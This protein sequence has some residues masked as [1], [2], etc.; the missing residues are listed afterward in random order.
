MKRIS[1]AFLVAVLMTVLIGCKPSDEKLTATVSQALNANP[2]L[3][4]VS[5]SVKEGVVTLSGEVDDDAL[6]AS[7]ESIAAA[8]KGVKS[9]TNALTVK[10]KGP[11]PEEL[12]K[13]ADDALV[14]KVV[15]N[16]SK[17]KVEGITATAS[18]GIVTL[19]GEIKRANLQNALKAAMESGASKV[20]NQLTIK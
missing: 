2:S 5:A 15:E 18:D 17:Y 10:P 20:E 3:S 13:A 9:V 4:V 6:K 8:V 11:S 19:T 7:A 14:A 16:F 1:P 12:K